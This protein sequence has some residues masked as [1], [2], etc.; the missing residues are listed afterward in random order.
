MKFFYS[1]NFFKTPRAQMVNIVD[2]QSSKDTL[3]MTPNKEIIYRENSIQYIKPTSVT[4][5]MIKFNSGTKISAYASPTTVTHTIGA[6]I[7]DDVSGF[8][9]GT[10]QL[11]LNSSNHDKFM[12][13]RVNFFVISSEIPID[14]L[15]RERIYGAKECNFKSTFS[16]NPDDEEF[17][18]SELDTYKH[19]S[20]ILGFI[21]SA[22]DLG[23]SNSIE[24]ESV[25]NSTCSCTIKLFKENI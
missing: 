16:F 7:L 17:Y 2:N 24:C 10:I 15:F 11:T 21:I 18:M 19:Q 14:T 9:S 4:S 13:F 22:S 5:D 8:N 1:K 12:S 25:R 6:V 23:D 3:L 20:K